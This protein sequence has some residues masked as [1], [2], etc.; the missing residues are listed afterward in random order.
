M[1]SA[2]FRMLRLEPPGPRWSGLAVDG[3]LTVPV[4]PGKTIPVF[5]ERLQLLVCIKRLGEL[6][7]T[8]ASLLATSSALVC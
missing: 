8:G 1:T 4:L 7:D 3:N 5:L 2:L 6:T